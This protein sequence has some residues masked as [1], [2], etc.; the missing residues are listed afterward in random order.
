MEA[1]NRKSDFMRDKLDV[2]ENF[3]TKVEYEIWELETDLAMATNICSSSRFAIKLRLEEL[4]KTR[5]EILAKLAH[6]SK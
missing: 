5:Q 2:W 3:L 6:H 1:T 4:Q